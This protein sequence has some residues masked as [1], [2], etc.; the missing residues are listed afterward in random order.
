[1]TQIS[2]RTILFADLRGSTGLFESLGNAEATS[3]VTHCVSSLT[4]AVHKHGGHVVKTLG[5]GLMAVF[6]SPAQAVQS[7]LQMHEVLAGI[8]ARG[9]ERGASSGLRALRLQ[10][11][12]SRGEVVEMAGDCFGDAVN[13]AARLLDHAGDNETLVT[14]AVL[15]G[16]TRTIKAMFRSLDQMVLRGRVEPVQVFVHGGRRSGDS[17]AT[18][19][20]DV[21][22]AVEPDAIR[23]QWLQLDLT[24]ASRQM[25]VVLGRS[26]QAHYCVDDSRVSRSHARLDWHGGSFQL[27]DLSYNGTYVRFGDGEIVSLRR[28]SCLLHGK[29]AIGLGGSPADP[30]SACVRF[31]VLRSGGTPLAG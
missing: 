12:V 20:G 28:G 22:P 5:D 25:P 4:P 10:V 24:F 19:F 21:S 29:G 30:T 27:S 18:Q 6:D 17:A 13:V 23:L 15:A 26:P 3:V 31:E 8:V 7:A 1:M 16:L 9:T 14:G 11:A 2:D